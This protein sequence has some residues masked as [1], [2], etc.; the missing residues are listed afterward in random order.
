MGTT[1]NSPISTSPKTRRNNLGNT[2]WESNFSGETDLKKEKNKEAARKARLRK[3]SYI[4]ELEQMVPNMQKLNEEGTLLESASDKMLHNLRN[5]NQ[6]PPLLPGGPITLN[7]EETR[8]KKDLSQATMDSDKPNELDAIVE[9][10]E[11]LAVPTHWTLSQFES[12][13]NQPPQAIAVS[14]MRRVFQ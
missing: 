7:S 5:Q 2:T 10:L 12:T 6:R 1:K 4:E 14:K 3:K 13:R 8:V 9:E 11:R